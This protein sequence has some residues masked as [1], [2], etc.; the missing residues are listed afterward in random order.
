[1]T[2]G[3]K[4]KIAYISVVHPL[5]DHRFLYKQCKGLADNG[6][7]VEYYVKAEKNCVIN[8]VKIIALKQHSN[9][10]KRFL[11]IFSI[12]PKLIKGRYNA[13]H[14]VDPE[15]LPLGMLLKLFTKSVIV[16]D[17]HED[18]VNF[19]S[20]KY[21]LPS[22]LTAAFSLG[23][24]FILYL[25]SLMLD[26]FVFADEGTAEEFRKLPPAR[27]LLFRNFPLL[28][29]FPDEP[30][31]WTARKYDVVFVGT[32]SQTGGIFV[33]LEA[34]N[35]VKDKYPPLK[36]LFIGQPGGEIKQQVDEYLRQNDMGEHI[37]FTGRIPHADVPNLLQQCKI[38]LIG[39]LDMPKFHKNIATKMFEYMASG[40]PTISSDLP[41][42]RKYIVSGEC[43]YLVPPGDPAAMAEAISNILSNPE[44]G[45]RISEACRRYIVDERYFAENEIE[46]LV[47]F[48]KYLLAHRRRPLCAS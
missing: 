30:K 12:L 23:V 17:A 16:F 9:R 4:A 46:K 19:M 38:G 47:K 39:L 31:N 7:D 21:Y 11:S 40:I 44:L 1:M 6:F 45:Q 34:V 14:L 37:E 29:L 20:H 18:Y 15:L 48:Y 28:S 5:H 42:E 2:D 27:K 26:G 13:V 35:I 10:L 22:F 36:C 3:T 8:N 25:S 33:M 41:P 32:M 43:G 24:K